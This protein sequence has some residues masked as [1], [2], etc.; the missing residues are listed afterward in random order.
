MSGEPQE[1]PL[2]EPFDRM[3]ADR[4]QMRE[5]NAEVPVLELVQFGCG[6]FRI[7]S[8]ADARD[9]LLELLDAGDF[10]SWDAERAADVLGLSGYAREEL[11]NSAPLLFRDAVVRLYERA[12]ES[13]K[14]LQWRGWALRVLAHKLRSATDGCR[15]Q[16]PR[17]RVLP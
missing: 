14:A 15:R 7:G 10:D 13:A 16:A 11:C 17:A 4:A 5:R 2:G 12:I 6:E 9:Y 8:L 3:L 1:I